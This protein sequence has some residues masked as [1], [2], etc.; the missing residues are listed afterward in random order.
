[1]T[2]VGKVLV[3]VQLIMS[4][5]FLAFAGAVFTAQT[6]WRQDATTARDEL[7]KQ[8]DKYRLDFEKFNAEMTAVKTE[9][10]NQKSRAEG[11]QSQLTA[12]VT[13]NKALEADKVRLLT[14]VDNHRTQAQLATDEATRRLEEAKVQREQNKILHVS[15]DELLDTKRVLEDEKFALEIAAKNRED[16]HNALLEKSLFYEKQILAMGGKLDIKA[17]KAQ[18]APPPAVEGLVLDTRKGTRDTTEFVEISLGSD[19]G[20][21]TGHELFV[22]RANGAGKYLGK[23]RIEHVSADRAVGTVVQ[24]AKNGTIQKGDNVS[25]KL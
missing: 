8:Q 9:R 2:F 12:A 25:S 24:K 20:L 13:A 5:C 19:D 7:K 4:V 17:V 3:G 22:Y 14:E 10:D 23:I 16:K 6:N 1:M 11:T 18:Q 21:F 15:R